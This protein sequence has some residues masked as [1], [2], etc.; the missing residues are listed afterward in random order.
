M[1]VCMYA[2]VYPVSCCRGRLTS[3][4]DAV[5]VAEWKQIR[6]VIGARD[7]VSFLWKWPRFVGHGLL[8]YARHSMN[9]HYLSNGS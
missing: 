4:V 7:N 1:Y 5:S 3:V 2:C 8:K 6:A 9:E